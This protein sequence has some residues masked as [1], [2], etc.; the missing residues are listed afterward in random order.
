MGW[1][2]EHPIQAEA[3][4][5]RYRAVRLA[6]HRNIRSIATLDRRDF[7]VYRLPGGDALH[8]VMEAMP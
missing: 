3:M 4:A 7:S 8:N 6:H 2:L 1:Q 5:D